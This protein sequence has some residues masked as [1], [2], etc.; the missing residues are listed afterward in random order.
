MAVTVSSVDGTGKESLLLVVR[1]PEP[2]VFA[3]HLGSSW[4]VLLPEA[5]VVINQP[6]PPQAFRAS[7]DFET[8]EMGRGTLLGGSS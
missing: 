2:V 7:G 8:K 1:L 6:A 5:S 3:H 4:W